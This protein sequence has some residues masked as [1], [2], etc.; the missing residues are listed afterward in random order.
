VAT[1]RYAF[2][3][4]LP[5]GQGIATSKYIKRVYYAVQSGALP[6]SSTT[7]VARQ[8]LDHIAYLAYGSSDLWWVIAAASGIGWNLQAP[9]GTIVR[10]PKELSRV[11]A[12]LR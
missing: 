10:I 2:T 1:S 11:F 8:R 4:L 7:L 12:L 9:A 6:F 3:S 5:G